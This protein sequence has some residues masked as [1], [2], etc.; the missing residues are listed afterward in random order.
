MAGHYGSGRNNCYQH[1]DRQCAH[2]LRSSQVIP[3]PR[4]APCCG[5][6][7]TVDSVTSIPVRH[8]SQHGC[9][10]PDVRVL[11]FVIKDDAVKIKRSTR[12]PF[13]ENQSTHC[14]RIYTSS[15]WTISHSEQ[16]TIATKIIS[17]Q[18]RNYER[19]HR[20]GKPY[21]Q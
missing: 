20:A 9:I 11:G 5:Y 16:T 15:I 12:G 13:P 8:S 14:S 19:P 7:L 3:K 6:V 10:E 4:D 18:Y 17:H 1:P 2:V 21:A